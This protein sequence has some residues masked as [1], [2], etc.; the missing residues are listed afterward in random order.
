M[1][2]EDVIFRLVVV[3]PP[4]ALF[5]FLEKLNDIPRLNVSR[6]LRAQMREPEWEPL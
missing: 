6:L 5:G 1:L 2:Q 4:K 3:D